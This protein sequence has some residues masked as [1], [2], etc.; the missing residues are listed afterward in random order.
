MHIIKSTNGE[1]MKQYPLSDILKCALKLEKYNAIMYKVLKKRAM[2]STEKKDF[3]ILAEES[4]YQMKRIISLINENKRSKI[5]QESVEIDIKQ[6]RTE[7]SNI[8]KL[9]VYKKAM[10]NERRL[11]NLYKQMD[12]ISDVQILQNFIRA[13]ILHVKIIERNKPDEYILS[14]SARANHCDKVALA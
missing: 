13:K 4:M 14:K 2:N 5:P 11:I 6:L 10:I 9:N 8:G 12:N 7:N 3:E 1:F